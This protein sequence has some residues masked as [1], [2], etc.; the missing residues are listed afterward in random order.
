[1]TVFIYILEQICYMLMLIN[2]PCL[3]GICL[4]P[5]LIK[6]S[7][8]CFRQYRYV[9]LTRNKRAHIFNLHTLN[10]LTPLLRATV[11]FMYTRHNYQSWLLNFLNLL[12]NIGLS[13]K[14]KIKTSREIDEITHLSPT[15]PLS[16]LFVL[17]L[18]T[19]ITPSSFPTLILLFHIVFNFFTPHLLEKILYI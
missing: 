13:Y 5:F 8:P 11:R 1:M 18:T 17:L 15:H 14:R 3:T 9:E 7:H 16:F 2:S 4:C 19:K 12:R 10:Y 6:K